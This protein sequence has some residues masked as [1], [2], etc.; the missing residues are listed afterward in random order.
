MNRW[1]TAAVLSGALAASCGGTT[2]STPDEGEPPQEACN[3]RDDDGDGHCDDTYACCAGSAVACTTRCGTTGWQRC[4]ADCRIPTSEVCR[5][6][7]ETC[8]NIDDDC[9]GRTD[10]VPECGGRWLWRNP[11]PSWNTLSAVW[12]LPDGT[13]WAV[14][15]GGA[16]ARWDGSAWTAQRSPTSE[17]L[18]GIA[19]RPGGPPLFAVGLHGTTLRFD[20]DAWARDT[21]PVAVSLHAVW[22]DASGTEAVAVGDQGTVL[23]WNG[24]D[25]FGGTADTAEDLFGVWGDSADDVFAVGGHRVLCRWDGSAWTAQQPY[26]DEGWLEGVWGSS[27]TDVYAVGRDGWILRFDGSAWRRVG[28]PTEEDLWDVWGT[29]DDDVYAAGSRG[30]M[31]HWDGAAWSPMPT[32]AGTSGLRGLGG[33]G[34]LDVWAVGEFGTV[35]RY[36]GAGWLAMEHG[37]NDD[38]EAIVSVPGGGMLA[39]GHHEDTA[40]N[41][42]TSVVWGSDAGWR[43]DL[44]SIRGQIRDA[45]AAAA[46]DAWVVGWTGT[47]HRFDGTAWTRVDSGTTKDLE[48]IWG[49]D[50]ALIYA[51]GEGGT[52]LR[53][54][55]AEWAAMES[56]TDHDLHDIRGLRPDDIW[57]VGDEGTVVHWDGTAWT[58]PTTN[59]RADLL[60]VVPAAAD[61]VIAVGGQPGTS[62]AGTGAVLRWDGARWAEEEEWFPDPMLDVVAVS[63]TDAYAVSGAA[64][65]HF[66]GYL[67]TALATTGVGPTFSSDIFRAVVHDPV[68]GL[69]TAGGHGAVLE[70]RP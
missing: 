65:W 11:L 5:T 68:R 64:T 2:N 54:D 70:W 50:P 36:Q 9:D 22:V 63:P 23:R 21:A 34:A 33:T 19:G 55:G 43:A 45:W 32:A 40:S 62:G 49:L 38:L 4:T 67:W 20:G 60:A 10:E 57:A 39:I 44:W 24:A 42:W 58:S 31:L 3:G 52:I 61:A 17:D 35:Q 66:D 16:I 51:A 46:D 47:I 69:L 56:S 29:A 15:A 48:A 41:L 37:P 13:A 7:S 28:L 59:S 25:W 12:P 18:R 53:W 30:T 27:G 8:N 14:G 1:R 26:T 6:P